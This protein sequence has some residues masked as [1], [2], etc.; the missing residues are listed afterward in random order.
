MGRHTTYFS[1]AP[2]AFEPASF[3]RT[4]GASG[5]RVPAIAGA[6]AVAFWLRATD[7]NQYGSFLVDFRTHGTGYWWARNAPA[8]ITQ[9]VIDGVATGSYVGVFAPGWHKVYLE[10]ATLDQA[11]YLLC[12]YTETEFFFPSD[13]ADITFY[14]RPFT[15][16]ELAQ[17]TGPLPTDG[18]LARYRSLTPNRTGVA[19]ATGRWPPLAIIG[20]PLAGAQPVVWARTDEPASF[21]RS[22]GASGLRVPAIAGAV[23][24]AFWLRAT[25]NGQQGRFVVDFRAHGAGYWWNYTTAT[26]LTKQTIDGLS[27]TTYAAIFTPGW[28]QVYLEFATLDQAFYLLCRYTEDEF[29]FPFDV[30]DITF[31]DRPFTAA[32]HVAGPLPTTGV[33]ARYQALTPSRTGVADATGRWPELAV[34]G[35]PLTAFASAALLAGDTA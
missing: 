16:V 3:L 6:V 23:A 20:E 25:D 8:G 26:G 35:E 1:T 10:F 7:A 22:T 9:S 28:H 11:F 34:I 27:T 4:T 29:F 15:A 24:V 18:V 31:Y 2:A 33:L 14:G 5:L 21:L 13:V 19:D 12:R 17:A 30:A 32:E